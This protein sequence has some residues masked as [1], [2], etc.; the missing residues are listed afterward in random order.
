MLKYVI[1][2]DCDFALFLGESDVP[3]EEFLSA[4]RSYDRSG[5]VKIELYDLSDVSSMLTNGDIRTIAS[6]SD[7]QRKARP[8]GSRTAIVVSKPLHRWLVRFYIILS[9][10]ASVNW[11]TRQFRTVSEAVKWLDVDIEQV[12]NMKLSIREES[13]ATQG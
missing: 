12:E 2:K 5:A 9:E 10:V 11:E 13:G 3:L 1:D 8:P 7:S 4:L 6:V